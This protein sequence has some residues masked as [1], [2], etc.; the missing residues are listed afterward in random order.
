MTETTV[1]GAPEGQPP[2]V[3]A[4]LCGVAPIDHNKDLVEVEM[5]HEHRTVVVTLGGD[6][7]LQLSGPYVAVYQMLIEA[8]KQ[9][10]RFSRT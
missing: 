10:A 4:R 2:E 5:D 9:L 7:G 8:D 3:V 1:T 6:N